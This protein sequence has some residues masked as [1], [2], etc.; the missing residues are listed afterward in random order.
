MSLPLNNYEKPTKFL[1]SGCSFTVS[2]S[3][4]AEL[5]KKIWRWPDPL[6]LEYN[7]KIINNL[8]IAGN[9]NTAIVQNLSYALEESKLVFSPE[10]TLVMF[11]ITG[12]DRIDLMV[13]NSHPDINQIGSWHDIFP[14]AWITSGGYVGLASGNAQKLIDSLHKNLDWEPIIMANC[15]TI[16]N[17]IQ[18]L[19]AD[20]YRYYFMLMDDQILN[21]SPKFFQNFI[22]SKSNSWITFGEYQSMHGYGKS[23]GLLDT[24]NFHLTLEGDLK[25]AEFVK[26]KINHHFI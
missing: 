7:I 9:G 6:A 18:R 4:P 20:G 23:L 1:V 2:G 5:Q 14:F 19:E 21:D 8:A 16:I 3:N 11:N 25:I 10:T 26:Q 17:F 24:D 13:P 22:K 15:L 12:L